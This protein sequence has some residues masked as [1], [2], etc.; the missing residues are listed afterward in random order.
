ML[1]ILIYI[2]VFLQK[3]HQSDAE[4]NASSTKV[5]DNGAFVPKKWKDIKAGDIL[6]IESNDSFPA[7]VILL[8]SSEPDGL[9]Y[10][11]TANLDG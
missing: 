11:E 5:L 3:R 4:L 1:L 7:D 2:L 6:R 8:S 9:A 10:I